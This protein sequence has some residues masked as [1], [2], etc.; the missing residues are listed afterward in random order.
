LRT[1]DNDAGR[2]RAKNERSK[3]GSDDGF[4]HVD[5]RARQVGS[6]LRFLWARLMSRSNG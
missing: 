1:G 4:V 6:G 5:L 3:A 2:G